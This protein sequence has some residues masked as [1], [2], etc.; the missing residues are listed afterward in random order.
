MRFGIFKPFRLTVRCF[1]W[2]AWVIIALLVIT[3]GS[4][5]PVPNH[6]VGLLLL[7]LG[8]AGSG[9]LAA[10]TLFSSAA[11]QRLVEPDVDLRDTRAHLYGLVGLGLLG[12]MLVS[13]ALGRLL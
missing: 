11:W 5:S 12:A 4:H 6:P 13:M 9:A 2:A 7:G 1:L 10:L 3:I 8:C